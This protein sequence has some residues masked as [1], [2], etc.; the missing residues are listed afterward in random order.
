MYKILILSILALFLINGC[1]ALEHKTYPDDKTITSGMLDHAGKKTSKQKLD[2]MISS[3]LDNTTGTAKIGNNLFPFPGNILLI[4]TLAIED[5]E[6]L[7]NIVTTLDKNEKITSVIRIHLP[8]TPSIDDIRLMSAKNGARY[9]IVF[10]EFSNHYQYH[11]AWTI[12]SVLGL[13]I[14]YFFLDTQTIIY[15]SKIEV[16]IFDVEAN[17][18]LLNESITANTE[19]EATKSDSGVK[20]HELKMKAITRGTKSLKIILARYI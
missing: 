12:P 14:P 17:T 5:T 20:S 10:N 4:N 11:N 3:Q 8:A 6:A 7:D 19:G 2:S 18:L 15:L 9:A 16:S 13:G 1:G